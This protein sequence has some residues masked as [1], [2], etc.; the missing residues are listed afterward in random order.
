MKTIAN[1]YMGDAFRTYMAQIGDLPLLSRAEELAVA[2]RIEAARQRYR[3]E[4]FAQDFILK[5]AL[6]L[7]RNVG[8]GGVRPR[9]ALEISANDPAE[10]HRLLEQMELDV[11][12]I[13]ELLRQNREDFTLAIARGLCKSRRQEAWRRLLFRRSE[14]QALAERLQVRTQPLR[15]AL[16]QLKRIS[17]EMDSIRAQLARR[18]RDILDPQERVELH[19]R[20][21]W[22][23]RVLRRFAAGSPES[24]S[25]SDSTR[26]PGRTCATATCG[27]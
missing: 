27:W 13:D 1:E 15:P 12:L 6:R 18:H 22:C 26:W 2:K 24:P 21:Q 8:A 5:A 20:L 14:A 17:A 3:R 7:L 23:W 4:L 16:E 25:S 19:R 9:E 11:E 10:K